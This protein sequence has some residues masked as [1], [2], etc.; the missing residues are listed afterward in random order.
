MGLSVELA[1]WVG[2]SQSQVAALLEVGPLFVH[3]HVAASPAVL[4]ARAVC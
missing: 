3:V 1:P 2:E 4:D